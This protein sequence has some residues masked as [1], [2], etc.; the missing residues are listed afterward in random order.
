MAYKATLLRKYFD[1]LY[2]PTHPLNADL[3]IDLLENSI[4]F[5]SPH[6]EISLIGGSLGGYYSI[7]LANKYNI[8]VALIN[9][10]IKPY[11][12]VSFL[13]KN[14]HLYDGSMF[15]LN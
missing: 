3:A 2:S 4:K 11:T 6:Y 10:A 8:K 12:L 5:F 15:T 9:P 7:Y 1:N 13:G 14:K